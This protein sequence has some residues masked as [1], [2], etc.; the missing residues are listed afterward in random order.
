[1]SQPQSAPDVDATTTATPE[2][3]GTVTEHLIWDRKRDS[4]F[5]ETKELKGRVRAV[6]DPE[7]DMGHIDR[8]LKKGQQDVVVGQSETHSTPDTL[9]KQPEIVPPTDLD[10]AQSVDVVGTEVAGTIKS[11]TG[12]EKHHVSINAISD[13]A[14]CMAAAKEDETKAEKG[15]P[16]E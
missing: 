15:R 2:T 7:K 11:A 5:P 3:Q 9:L 6:I 12:H 14:E 10:G 8:A 16:L 13:C 4:G 1:M